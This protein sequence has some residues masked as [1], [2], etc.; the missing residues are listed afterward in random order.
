[1]LKAEWIIVKPHGKRKTMISTDKIVT[2]S[3]HKDNGPYFTLLD[4]T[5]MFVEDSIEYIV[6][7]LFMSP[8][9][10]QAIAEMKKDGK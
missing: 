9:N 6:N 1:M 10:E 3:T 8:D 2:V 7:G 4:G 5:T